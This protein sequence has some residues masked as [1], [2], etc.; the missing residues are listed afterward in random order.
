MDEGGGIKLRGKVLKRKTG[1]DAATALGK[2]KKSSVRV[3][4]VVSGKAK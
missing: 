3:K 4:G 2:K 1:G